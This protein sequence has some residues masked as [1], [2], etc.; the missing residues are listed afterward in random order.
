MASAAFKHVEDR[1]GLQ[2]F[3]AD[4]DRRRLTGAAVKAVLRLVDAWDGSNAEG[5]A[6]LGV[7]ESTWDRMKAGTWEGTLSQDQLTRA[8]ALIGLFKGLHLLFAD[9]MADRWPKL[10]NKA[11]VFDRRS[12]VQA[13]I[14]GGIPRMLETRQYIDALRGGL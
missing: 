13:M 4:D 10:A 6:L 9:D 2:T 8:S 7:S 3:A 12:P 14:A 11:P 5:A 1:R